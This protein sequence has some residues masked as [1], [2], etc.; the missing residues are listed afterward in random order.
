MKTQV[1]SPIL[2]SALQRVVPPDARLEGN[3]RP[4]GDAAAA[5]AISYSQSSSDYRFQILGVGVSG[6][7][8]DWHQSLG[9][10]ARQVIAKAG[11][12]LG[13]VKWMI[14]H[15]SDQEFD[16]AVLRIAPQASVLTR[17]VHAGA[18]L[19]CGDPL[20]SLARVIANQGNSLEGIGL[21]WFRGRFGSAGIVALNG[22]G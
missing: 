7:T 17:D 12:H 10:L 19:G 8:H 13:L 4:L 16:D 20:V 2:V 21:L 15:R 18:N 1:K 11:L 9:I 6:K 5:V 22:Q 3:A 14:I